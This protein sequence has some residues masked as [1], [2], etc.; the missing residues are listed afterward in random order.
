MEETFKTPLPSGRPGLVFI[1]DEHLPGAVGGGLRRGDNSNPGITR[2]STAVSRDALA[3]A[4]DS[5]P[6]KVREEPSSQGRAMRAKES[7]KNSWMYAA[8]RS[9]VGMEC[10]RFSGYED[11]FDIHARMSSEETWWL[12]KSAMLCHSNWIADA[13]NRPWQDCSYDCRWWER[14]RLEL[15]IVGWL[16]GD[17][18]VGF[19]RVLGLISMAVAPFL[20][21]FESSCE[22][23]D[24]RAFIA[25]LKV[26]HVLTTVVYLLL[27]LGGLWAEW[28]MTKA[29]TRSAYLD[30]LV[31][32]SLIAEIVHISMG[33]PRTLSWPQIPWLLAMVKMWRWTLPS[34]NR[35]SLRAKFWQQVLNLFIWLCMFTHWYACLFGLMGNIENAQGQATWADEVLLD[36]V[37]SCMEYYLYA[38]YF[39]A[40][41]VTSIG[42]GDV[43]PV[44][45]FERG[46]VALC[47]IASQLYLAKV[48][49]DLNFYNS[50][51]SYWEA[52]Q[53]QMVAMTSTAMDAIGAPHQFR[54]RV[55]AYQN[56]TWQVQKA[57]CVRKGFAE[58]PSRLQEEANIFLNYTFV[59]KAPFLQQLS[60]PALRNIISELIDD[61][62]LPSD[63]VI[64]RGDVS[65]DLY[66]L[67]DG[68]S[69]VFLCEHS[70]RWAE[71]EV[72]VMCAGDYFGE[73]GALTGQPRSCWVM[74]RTYCVCS[75][76]PKRAI[77]DVISADPSCMVIL[78]RSLK[79][80][81]ILK[82]GMAWKEVAR[83][84]E[85]EFEDEDHAY[86]FICSGDDGSAPAGL[87]TWDRYRQ[88]MHRLNVKDIDQKLLWADV[89]HEQHGGVPFEEFIA[90]FAETAWVS[91]R[92][93]GSPRGKDM[94][95]SDVTDSFSDCEAS[96]VPTRANSAMSR[97]SMRSMAMA[98]RQSR[99]RRRSGG[100]DGLSSRKECQHD[101]RIERLTMEVSRV[102]TSLAAIAKSL[103]VEDQRHPEPII[104]TTS[105]PDHPFESK[106]KVKVAIPEGDNEQ[107]DESPFSK[108][109]T[110]PCVKLECPPEFPSLEETENQAKEGSA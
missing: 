74:A 17:E 76:L 83:R 75:V 9:M 16:S 71:D 27:S 65:S 35:K 33:P 47:M 43:T 46:V 12:L 84:L 6:N 81:L 90:A 7:L 69:G 94:T 102:S 103:G 50:V 109:Q 95:Y 18:A 5:M 10:R 48:F 107:S 19:L 68:I 11:N 24:E 67:R 80:S 56:Y 30:L 20:F 64:R 96:S 59:I 79:S 21:V 22:S 15:T 72:S 108:S 34:T 63:F 49:A 110:V 44:N 92:S 89:D 55:G 82:P 98:N 14:P 3:L 105:L 37:T 42:Y 87:V 8:K 60:V 70:P 32:V 29:Y 25:A 41:T 53:Q 100:Q 36:G 61:T 77:D 13:S 85:T 86:D 62:Y 106:E 73:V 1:S 101:S 39:S 45:A 97:T 57:L 26:A 52:H 28:H 78:A 23:M 104:S 58:L 88:L 54:Q 4:V 38:A 2:E 99:R 93:R 66:F 51:V 91:D 40:Y 31:L